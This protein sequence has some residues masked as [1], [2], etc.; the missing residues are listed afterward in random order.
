VIVPGL[1]V[2][3]L[4]FGDPGTLAEWEGRDKEESV[5]YGKRMMTKGSQREAGEDK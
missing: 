4:S 5:S 3:I 2:A 1:P